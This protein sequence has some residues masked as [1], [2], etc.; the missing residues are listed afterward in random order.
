M[1]AWYHRKENKGRI[2]GEISRN[3]VT[4]TTGER[5]QVPGRER[6]WGSRKEA[7]KARRKGGR[8]VAIR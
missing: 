5:Q 3:G 4:G 6:K 1:V 2:Q 7:D 8:L